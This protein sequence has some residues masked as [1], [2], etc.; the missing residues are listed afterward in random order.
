MSDDLLARVQATNNRIDNMTPDRL[1]QVAQEV[2][3]RKPLT[4]LVRIARTGNLAI[5]DKYTDESLG[6]ID[7]SSGQVWF[8]DDDYESERS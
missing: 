1:R 8:Y 5:V 4:R 2:V 7:L 3:D 6:H